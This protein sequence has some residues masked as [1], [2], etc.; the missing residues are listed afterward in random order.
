MFQYKFI[1]SDSEK[2]FEEKLNAAGAE[3]WGLSKFAVHDS[4][5]VSYRYNAVMSKCERPYDAAMGGPS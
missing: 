5:R 3:G 1:Q 2:D 4:S